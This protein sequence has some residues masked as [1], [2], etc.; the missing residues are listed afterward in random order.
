MRRQHRVRAGV[1]ALALVFA[2]GAC[3]SADEPAGS[4]D[5]PLPGESGQYP[6]TP[7]PMPSDLVPTELPA[8]IEAE[9][10]DATAARDTSTGPSSPQPWPEVRVPSA[11]EPRLAITCDEVLSASG[12]R[13]AATT[14]IPPTAQTIGVRQG[15]G[16]VCGF[17]IDTPGG[18]VGAVLLLAADVDVPATAVVTCATN[19]WKSDTVNCAGAA[20]SVHGAAAIEYE[21]PAGSDVRWGT[22]SAQALLGAAASILDTRPAL[23]PVPT[24]HPDS[25]GAEQK[26]C[27]PSLEQQSA[28][29]ELFPAGEDTDIY[30]GAPGTT[31][32]DSTIHSRVGTLSCVWWLGWQGI[33]IEVVPGAGW[34][35]D[36]LDGPVVDVD[37]AVTAI[38]TERSVRE[39]RSTQQW[40]MPEIA[41]VASA[42]GSAIIVR[43]I[44]EESLV[45]Y[46]DQTLPRVAEAIIR[47]QP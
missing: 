5:D 13:D 7:S 1:A 2:L 11:P 6:G 37:G 39:Y 19:G 26:Y 36:E 46:F 43:A 34:I 30:G 16:T 15:G 28:V 12:V 18:G 27:D 42:R 47:T 20:A 41:I 10:V 8:A 23:A 32:V 29:F 35:A 14:S 45:P 4:A 17:M 21:M 22:S 31:H 38:R 25:M 33:T 3:A 24:T 9:I 44:V 40:L